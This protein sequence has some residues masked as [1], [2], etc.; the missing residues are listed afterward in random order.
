MEPQGA[1][2]PGILHCWRQC[3]S[4]GLEE[5]AASTEHQGQLRVLPVVVMLGSAAAAV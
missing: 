4:V 1:A 3:D 2:H 5:A